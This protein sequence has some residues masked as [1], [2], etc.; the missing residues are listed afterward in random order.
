MS[1]HP[2]TVDLTRLDEAGFALL[3]EGRIAPCFAANEADRATAVVTLKR[4]GLIGAPIVLALALLV[5]AAFREGGFVLA[6]VLFGGLGAAWWAYAPVEAVRRRVKTQS[7]TAIAEAMGARFSLAVPA[8]P[9]LSRFRDLDLLPRYDIS[10]FE[11]LFSGAHHGATFDLYEAHLQQRRRSGKRTTTVTV[12]R[13]QV[14]RLVFPRKF[15]GVTIVRRDAGVFNFLAGLGQLKRVGLV[16]PKFEKVFEVY[17]TD[18]VE[19]RFLVHPAFMERLMEMEASLKGQ[20]LR[21]A[22]QEG[23]LLIAIE[24]ANLFEPGSMFEPL[25][26]PA[27]ARRIV[28]EL[29]SLMRVVDAVLTA[30][31]QR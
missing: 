29:A 9:G 5:G 23:D 10:S 21:C 15:E 14:I 16:D 20:R 31:A 25:V 18:Q 12:F 2:E 28:D 13:G 26:S 30:Q 3:Y 22:F 8:P 24:G 4:R 1:G 27:R 17:G 19:A 11:D 7:L 6:A